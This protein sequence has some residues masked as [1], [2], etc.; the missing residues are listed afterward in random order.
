MLTPTSEYVFVI[1]SEDEMRTVQVRR[2]EDLKQARET[3]RSKYDFSVWRIIN[4]A[5]NPIF[6]G[7]EN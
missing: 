3:L 4:V 5:Q 1:E 2:V 7:A 6:A